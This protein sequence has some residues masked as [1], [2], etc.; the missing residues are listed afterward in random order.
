M[1]A[2]I[3]LDNGLVPIRWQTIICT[4]GD[5]VN[6]RICVTVTQWLNELIPDVLGTVN[7][8]QLRLNLTDKIN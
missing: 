7:L 4:N 2:N 1:Y 5:Q 8:G 6:W 3:G